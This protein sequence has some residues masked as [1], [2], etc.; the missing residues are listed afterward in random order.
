MGHYYFIKC[1]R[2]YREQNSVFKR[3]SIKIIDANYFRHVKA[4]QII[5]VTH[6]YYFKKKWFYAQS[7]LPS[8]II[9]F[10]RNDILKK[11]G[12]PFGDSSILPTWK[13][14]HTASSKVT[15][16]LSGDGADEL[17]FG[18]KG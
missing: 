13:L 5:S 16:I 14:S 2:A 8:W 18:Y 3:N 10:L 15:V 4:D 9:R 6:P 17:F 12:E 11:V 7:N 1:F